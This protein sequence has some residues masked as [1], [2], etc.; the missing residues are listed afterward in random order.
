[1]H[2]KGYQGS[3]G[4]K[5]ISDVLMDLFYNKDNTFK[6]KVWA[7]KRGF[8][9]PQV[10]NYGLNNDN[11]QYYLSDFDYYKMYPINGRFKLWI[12]DKL[13]IKY[14]LYPFKG[15]LPEYY[16]HI[17]S[18]GKT[19]P[20]MDG[21]F[22]N[23]ITDIVELLKL[24]KELALKL[25]AGSLGVGF[26]KLSFINNEFYLDGEIINGDQLLEFL[27][28]LKNY[29]VTEYIIPHHEIR[30]IYSLTANTIRVMVLNEDGKE[31]IIANAFI[32]F[33]TSITGQVDNVSVGGI[34]A[35][36]DINSGY[37][38]NGKRIVN[39][40][41]VCCKVH[42]DT[43]VPIEGKLPY[44]D[45]IKQKLIE[46]SIYLAE[47]KYMGFDVAITENGF[48]IIEINSHQDIKW[49]QYYYPLLTNNEAESFFR[50]LIIKK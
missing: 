32:R 37:Y 1:M 22:I 43:K 38:H 16:C 25:V 39:N 5:L 21:E 10:K 6:E 12:D 15:Y 30:K 42:P 47:V 26:H 35:I 18:R 2:K 9:S 27:F 49:Y 28:Q 29:L 3:F 8:L 34:C 40:K 13:T 11:F 33:G 24:R 31:P 23:N 19:I 44:W 20:L 46:I 7:Y 14:I 41:L 50:K 4:V 48:K 36:I 17:I 45:F